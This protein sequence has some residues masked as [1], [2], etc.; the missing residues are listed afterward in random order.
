[1][2]FSSN[3]KLLRKRR[4]RTQDEVAYALNMKRPT[5]SGYENQVAQPSVDVLI[6]FADYYGV[7][8]DTLIRVDLSSLT[9]SMVGQIERGIDVYSRGGKLRILA[10]TVNNQNRE[11]IEL[12]PEK[13]KAGYTRGFAD[14]EFVAALPVFNLPFLPE[15]RKFRTFQITGDSMLPIPSGAWVTGEY[16][17]DWTTIRTGPD[18]PVLLLPKTKDWYLKSLKI[19]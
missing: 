5:L 7:S 1:M 18:K 2:Y 3:I 12:V 15:N 14:P 17:V 8:I 4:G 11:N 13:A 19:N 10:T 6:A 9:E 16:V